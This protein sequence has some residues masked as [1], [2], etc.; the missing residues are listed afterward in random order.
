MIQRHYKYGNG[1]NNMDFKTNPPVPLYYTL[2]RNVID[3]IENEELKPGE[4]IPSERELIERYGL[5]RTTVRK[6]IDVLVNDGYLYKIQGKGTFVQNKKIEQGLIK[7]TSCT[8]GIK[9]LGLTPG[10]KL[11]EQKIEIPRKTISAHLK[12]TDNDEVFK[13]NRVLYGDD[14]PI[15]YTKSYIVYKYVK[16]IDKYDFGKESLYNIIENQ[17]NIKITHAVRTVEAILADETDVNLLE[18][19]L[20]SPILLFNGVVYGIYNGQEVPI[21][22]FK[23]RYRCDKTKFYIDQ[24]R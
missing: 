12:L 2:V 23:A 11:V 24:I 7:L 3:M 16:G 22:Y 15:N 19:N 18:V 9:N 17:F 8:E 10:I 20:N 14:M 1:G 5:S 21:E 4:A 6:A 13:T